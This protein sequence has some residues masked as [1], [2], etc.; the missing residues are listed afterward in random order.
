MWTIS[1]VV[2]TIARVT[3]QNLW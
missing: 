2:T 3:Q 1:A